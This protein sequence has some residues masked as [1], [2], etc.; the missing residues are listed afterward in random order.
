M[1]RDC[2]R[3][4]HRISFFEMGVGSTYGCEIQVA[5]VNQ[6]TGK[7][8]IRSCNQAIRHPFACKFQEK[9]GEGA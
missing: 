7:T 5:R 3:C 9:D 2:R 4:A 6:T 1:R 8:I